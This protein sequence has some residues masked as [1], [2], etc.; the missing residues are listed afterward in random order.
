MSLRAGLSIVICCHGAIDWTR[1]AVMGLLL[2]PLPFEF[3]I[4]VVDDSSEE[5]DQQKI[6]AL[7]TIPRV[8]LIRLRDRQWYPAAAN[9]GVYSASFS[10]SILLNSDA[11]LLASSAIAIRE[12]VEAAPHTIVGPVSN[13]GGYQSVPWNLRAEGDYPICTLPRRTSPRRLVQEW[14]GW[15]RR[16]TVRASLLNGFCLGFRTE[17]FVAVGG[18]DSGTFRRGYGEEFDLCLRWADA[19]GNMNVVTHAYV[20]HAKTRS[21]NPDLRY[22]LILQSRRILDARHGASVVRAARQSMQTNPDLQDARHQMA[23]LY[24]SIEARHRNR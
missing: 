7:G 20:H 16:A 1:R 11:L 23:L 15:R 10:H 8:R 18:Y 4:V 17:D 13:A 21:Y 9:H 6:K 22:E 3:E 19:G 14:S 2:A 12:A 5:R 24:E